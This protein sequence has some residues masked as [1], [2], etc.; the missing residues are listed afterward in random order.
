M[1]ISIGNGGSGGMIKTGLF[2][3][4]GLTLGAILLKGGIKMVDRMTGNK[5]PAEFTAFRGYRYQY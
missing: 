5:I 2:L 1:G 4:V 3:G